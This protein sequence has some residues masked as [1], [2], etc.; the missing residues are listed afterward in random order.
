MQLETPIR[1]MHFIGIGGIGMSGLALVL[2]ELGFE[3]QGSDLYPSAVT[4]MLTRHGIAVRLGHKPEN[5]GQAQLVI[6]T[7]A[8]SQ[9]NPELQ[10]ARRR[11]LPVKKRARL[12]G[13]I[14]LRYP[15][16]LAIAGTHGK[17]TTTAMVAGALQQAGL[18][19]T[20]FIGGLLKETGT[21]ARL[22]QG[23]VVV[24]E[25]DEY[26]RSFLELSPTAALITTLD[27]DHLDVYGDLEGVQKAFE[28]FVNRV[29]FWG[30]VIVNYDD[31]GLQQL[32]ARLK[33]PYITYGFSSQAQYRGRVLQAAGAGGRLEVLQH[34]SVLG[35]ITLRV[36]GQHNLQNA[37][38]AC[39]LCLENGVPFAAVQAALAEFTGIKRRFE[40]RGEVA[41]VLFLDD[42]AHHPA[43]IQATLEAARQAYPQRRLVV[44]F[45]PH[46]YSRTQDF[47][48]EFGEALSL[49]DVLFLAPIYP[50][51]EAPIPHVSSGLIAKY[52][53]I[54]T[55][56]LENLAE[57]PAAVVPQLQPGD[58]VFTMGAGNIDGQQEALQAAWRE[59]A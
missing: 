56:V 13:E 52:T 7:S 50:A 40:L 53:T 34:D 9:D 10:E 11:G 49:A 47:A 8:V 19:P 54:P 20:V 46:L 43:E 59:K 21:N 35:I 51:R 32:T 15:R 4:D 23:E 18:D 31:P 28:E 16:R 36:P 39:A 33:Q 5:L 3:V 27:A 17:T 48:A 14:A 38:G 29:P 37:L 12:L 25:A 1:R 42:Y 2:R 57:L 44:L 6:Y 30:K 55:T 24:L 26:D 22:G 41:E 58:V 45:Q